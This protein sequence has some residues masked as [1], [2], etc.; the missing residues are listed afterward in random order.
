[1]LGR[2][3]L[4]RVATAPLRVAAASALMLRARRRL[5]YAASLSL[6]VREV[7]RNNRRTQADRPAR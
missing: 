6:L 4:F 7:E 5:A 1:M 3:V 2:I